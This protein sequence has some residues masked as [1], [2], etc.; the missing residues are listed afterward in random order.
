[1]TVPS[2]TT[3]KPGSVTAKAYADQTGSS[4]NIAPTSFTVPGLASTPQA[5]Q[6]YARSSAPMTGG[7]SGTVPVVDAALE[8]QT[9]AALTTALAPDLLASIQTQIPSGYVLLKGAATTIY[10][11]VTS[12]PSSTTG[13]IDVKEQGTMTAVVFP[14]S[15][16][17]K[18]VA[19]SV[20]G[21]GYNAEPLTLSSSDGLQLTPTNG[22]PDA[23]SSSFS[24]TITGTAPL[25]YSVDP[26][27]IAAAVSGK[28]RSEAEVALTNY[29]EVKR[30]II[31]LRPFWRQTFPEDPSSISIVTADGKY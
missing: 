1:M 26:A 22:L 11:E 27:R 16:L 4:Y 7:A 19:S 14:N 10:Q 23:Q 17:A 12:E 2:G 29:P 24:F 30:A 6:V 8:A 15:S 31:I 20:S 9:R 3:S 25:V 18:A 5:S 13:M 21:I 28:T